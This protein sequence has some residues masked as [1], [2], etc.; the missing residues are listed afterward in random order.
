MNNA[1]AIA[2]C[3]VSTH[4]QRLSNSL[5][6]QEESVLKAA[7]EL[8]VE[9]DRWWSGDVSSKAGTNVKRKDLNEMIDYCKNHKKVKYLIVDEPDRFMRSVDEAFYFEVTFRQLGVT[10]WYAS[11][12]NL[13]SGDLM[14]KLLKFSKY[15]PAEGSNVE[16]QTKS[17]TGHQKAIREG[18]YTFPV[19]PG[20]IKGDE[21]GVHVPHPITFKPFQNALKEVLSSLY[22]PREALT[23]LNQ[24]EFTKVHAAWNM[25]KFRHF[26]IDPYY[27]GIVSMDKQVKQQNINGLHQAVISLEEHE[28][29]LRI[30]T[31]KFKSRGAKKQYN[32]DFPMNKI[33]VCGDCEGRIKFTGSIKNN[34]YNRKKTSYYLKYECRRCHKSYHRDLVHEEISK[35]L[36]EIQYT[37]NQRKEFEE[38]LAIV[39]KQKQKDKLQTIKTIQ[40]RTDKLKSTKSKLIIE[41]AKADEEYKQD[42]KEEIDRIKTQISDN[43]VNVKGYD[44]LENDLIEFVKF[45][46]EYTNT[47]MDDYWQLDYEDRLR[48]QQLILPGGISFNSHKKVGTD[49]IS[50]LYFFEP[51]KK[52]LRFSRKSLMVELAEYC[53]P[54]PPVYL[55]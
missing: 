51:N 1:L 3:R 47:L 15:F 46:L 17:I 21:P 10:V 54:R 4:E 16:R 2:L 20:Y 30:F 55:G 18:R 50:S 52:D 28:E 23:R 34:G 38:A 31:G 8:G 49:K 9:V 27:A 35:R 48:C 12:N 37:G 19:K 39:W 13:N 26:A 41:M 32:P 14:A 7:G 5:N 44:K 6:R 29:L 43:E 25:T 11:D 22:E 36:H 42:F 45:G 40:E 53:P 33:M 24:S